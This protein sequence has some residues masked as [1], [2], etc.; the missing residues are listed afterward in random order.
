MFIKP[1]YSTKQ[2]LDSYV[3]ACIAFHLH[4]MAM[5]LV[6]SITAGSEFGVNPLEPC[7]GEGDRESN[8]LHTNCCNKSSNSLN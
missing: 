6:A 1:V 8:R 5:H 3:D 2:E 7:V 4:K